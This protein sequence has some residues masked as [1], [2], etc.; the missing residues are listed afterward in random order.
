MRGRP[1]FVAAHPSR[2][3]NDAARVGHPEFVVSQVLKCE[4]GTWGTQDDSRSLLLAFGDGE[5]AIDFVPVDH[6]PPRSE[7]IGTAILIFEIVG[8]LPNVIEENGIE[9][10]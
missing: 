2:K 3:D 7:V 10:L 5:A 4:R 1:R 6:V 9:A 8:V